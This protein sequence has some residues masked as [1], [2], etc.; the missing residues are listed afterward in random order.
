MNEGASFSRILAKSPR[1]HDVLQV[2]NNN[3]IKYGLYAGAYVS[4]VTSNRTPTD[5]DVLIADEDF[6]RLDGLFSESLVKNM[7][8]ARLF[9]P[10]KDEA[11]EMMSD[12][13]IDI[14]KSHYQFRLT[15]LAWGNTSILN[16]TGGS[17]ILCNPADTILL[18]AILQRGADENKHDLEDIED[19]IKKIQVD[20][21]YL[22]ERLR[23]IGPDDRILGVLERFNLI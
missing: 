4:I 8:D 3:H 16:Y 9:Y 14:K 18:K 7:P 23:Q 17:V 12:Q 15:D 10:Y 13:D 21:T 5:V 11:I 1:L 22:T 6:N 20:K 19:L 2:L